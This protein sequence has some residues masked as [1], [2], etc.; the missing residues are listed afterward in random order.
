MKK[1]LIVIIAL[2]LIMTHVIPPY[3]IILANDEVNDCEN[4]DFTVRKILENDKK[5]VG[6][7]LPSDQLNIEF[8]TK[9]KTEVIN[10]SGSGNFELTVEEE[11]LETNDV[12]TISNEHFKVD[13]KVASEGTA[14]QSIQSSQYVEC[15]VIVEEE[16]SEPE[17]TSEETASEEEV[18]EPEE[19]PEGPASE[20]EVSESEETPEEIA[21]VEE[22][23]ES[24]ETTEEIASEEEASESEETP[25][26]TASE[27][28][29]SESEET[30]EEIASEE[31]ASE[32]EE[33]PEGP[34]S[35]EEVSESEET[36][37]EAASEGEVSESEETPE[38][39]AS[40]EEASESE[41]TPE[42]PASE[43]E[44]SE[45]E[46]TPEEA[47]SEGEVSEGEGV[48]EEKQEASIKRI[49][50][51]ESNVRYTR[52]KVTNT[53][54][55][56]SLADV[57]LLTNVRITN[58]IDAAQPLE[59]APY[60]LSLSLSGSGL[61]DIELVDT[62][63][64]VAFSIP[65]LAGQMTATGSANVSVDLTLVNL[66]DLP[67]LG[68]VVGGLTGTLTS[69]VNGVL[70]LVSDLE[71]SLIPDELIT[72]EGVDELQGSLDALNNIEQA[73]ADA[74]QYNGTAP[75]TVKEDGTVTVNMT[76][77]LGSNLETA[78][79]STVIGTLENLITSLN[80][81]SISILPEAERI[82]LLGA[83]VRLL[84]GTINTTLSGLTGLAGTVTDTLEALDVPGLTTE[85]ARTQLLGS[86]NIDLNVEV[87]NP[88]DFEQG[89]DN[90][91][92]VYGSVVNTAEIDA[93]LIG[94]GTGQ[95]EII[96]PEQR[97]ETPPVL[98]NVDIDGNATDGYTVTG[99][100]EEPG[101]IVTVTSSSGVEVGSGTIEADGTF[102]IPLTDEVFSDEELHVQ[103]TDEAGNES[104]IRKV[105]VPI[106]K[107]ETVPNNI[108]FENIGIKNEEAI[109]GRNSSDN[110]IE[111]KDT[112]K[113]DDWVLTAKA[114]NLS[115]GNNVLENAL[116]YMRNGEEIEIST[117]AA[118]V[119]E[120]TDTNVVRLED[121]D[122]ITWNNNDG[123]L[124]KVNPIE[125]V[126]GEEYST[127]INWT[128]TDGP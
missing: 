96:F 64:V 6:T 63:R 75:V 84:N 24:E 87:D 12:I 110:I 82:P 81:V 62:N 41:E 26:E 9:N 20:E 79:N 80:G 54:S 52:K 39:I 49:V 106:L 105:I 19:T 40:E 61:A 60:T 25:E 73:L 57:S 35:E 67:I 95:S 127:T 74:L 42:G 59:G 66:G 126:A 93:N 107:L 91:V 36:P 47:A 111:I 4:M 33:T 2:V 123:L 27:E 90:I 113:T 89:A 21:N 48:S 104:E 71:S 16:V 120:S 1:N 69:T 11:F 44:V 94:N 7:S 78:V 28:E 17:E 85:L 112:R 8:K 115:A 13:T 101:D 45:S 65:E 88:V 22:V 15:P 38:E 117:E 3:N 23:S 103:A 100:G 70:S 92:P 37:E 97:D 29:V 30:P 121:N 10:V 116:I 31:E 122:T 124:L 118:T 51:Y 76:D 102:S 125:A 119:A 58:S 72:I 55:A 77:G 108:Q 43:E 18:P 86:T 50:P 99:T 32:S 128:L 109:F 46:E 56:Q 53:S 114:P 68:N 5:I 34:A 98:K 14:S 83:V